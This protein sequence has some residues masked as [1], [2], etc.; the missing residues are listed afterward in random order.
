MATVALGDDIIDSRDVETR[1]AELEAQDSEDDGSGLDE[2][3]RE[4]LVQLSELRDDARDY[5]ADWQYGAT[6]I[7]DAYFEDYARQFA[8]DIGAIND[9]HGWPMDYIDWERA[10]DALKMDY[11]RVDVGDY[12]YWVR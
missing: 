3:E 4:E 11:S 2:W 6:L 10:A 8:E 7:L 5:S 9:E 1:I 12:T